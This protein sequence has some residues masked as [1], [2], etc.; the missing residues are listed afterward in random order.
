MLRNVNKF[1]HT[2][3]IWFCENL[4]E[5][6]WQNVFLVQKNALG[7]TMAIA[8]LLLHCMILLIMACI[9]QS[10]NMHSLA[11][12][13][14]IYS[15]VQEEWKLIVKVDIFL[16]DCFVVNSVW[17]TVIV[18]ISQSQPHLCNIESIW[19]YIEVFWKYLSKYC[20]ARGIIICVILSIGLIHKGNKKPDSCLLS[21]SFSYS[22]NLN[23]NWNRFI[24]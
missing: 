9:T 20:K 15:Q 13:H 24:Y 18:V 4:E 7:F 6:N 1:E 3:L 11:W 17:V 16:W 5:Q 8:C 2:N 21:G 22:L 14:M 19:C 23:L 10:V 12:R